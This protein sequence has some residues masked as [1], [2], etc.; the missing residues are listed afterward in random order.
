MKF[1]ELKTIDENSQQSHEDENQQDWLPSVSSSLS[2]FFSAAY[3]AAT[4]TTE[5]YRVASGPT[6]VATTIFEEQELKLAKEVASS[7]AN[8]YL[9]RALLYY[10]QEAEIQEISPKDFEIS[11]RQKIREKAHNDADQEKIFTEINRLIQIDTL[12]NCITQF[13]EEKSDT[14]GNH[15]TSSSEKNDI[16]LVFDLFKYQ[17]GDITSETGQETLKRITSEL[18][19]Q[20]R[21]NLATLCKEKIIEEIKEIS[22]KIDKSTNDLKRENPAPASFF[23]YLE[24]YDEKLSKSARLFFTFIESEN[25]DSTEFKLYIENLEASLRNSYPYSVMTKGIEQLLEKRKKEEKD[26][27]PKKSSTRRANVSFDLLNSRF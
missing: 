26:K 4:T 16:A 7:V 10:L 21:N 17:G 3:D 20:F 14:S 22:G 12:N 1:Y 2:G 11:I 18:G 5:K 25:A 27:N 24:K 9:G 15:L 8:E 13:N 23:K 19:I 6:G